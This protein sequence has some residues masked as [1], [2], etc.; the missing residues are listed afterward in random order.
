MKQQTRK[1][2]EIDIN[3][4]SNKNMVKAQKW[5]K[6]KKEYN[7]KEK[8]EK[9][10]NLNISTRGLE[11]ELDLSDF[12]NLEK[13]ECSGNKLTNLN[14]SNCHQ[15]KALYC[16]HNQLTSLNLSKCINLTELYCFDNKLTKLDLTDLTQLE[17]IGC[18][19]NYLTNFDYSSLSSEK[20]NWLNI[21]NNN[22]P[23]QDLSVFSRFINLEGLRIGN[24]DQEKKTKQNIYNRFS[25]S[26]ESLKNLTKLR[27]LD[28]SNTDINRGWECLPANMKKISFSSEERPE[29]KVKEISEQLY[30]ISRGFDIQQLRMW[31]DIGFQ[32]K[33][34]GFAFY[35]T[36]QDY[37]PQAN[38][39]YE[40]L[41]VEYY[42]KSRK[43]Q[44]WLD[45]YYPKEERSE[46]YEIYLNEP[47]LEGELDLGAFTYPYGCGVRVYISP[48]VDETKLI[49][50]NLPKKAEI[51]FLDIQKYINQQYP[52][53]EDREKVTELN[54]SFD[55]VSGKRR[56]EGN[57]DLSEFINLEELTCIGTRLVSLNLNNCSQLEKVNVSNNQL[58]NLDVSNCF[59]LTEIDCRDNSLTDIT[60]PTDP[61]NLKKLDL[62][63]NDFCQDLCF[64]GSYTNLEELYLWNNKFTGSL[65][66][67]SGMKKLR[68]LDISNTDINEVNIDKLPRSLESIKYSTDYNCKLA[69]IVPQLDK[70]KYAFC[71]K[72]QQ[73]NTNN[74]WCQSCADKNWQKNIENLTGKEV[75][76]RFIER[77][78]EERYSD[79]KWIPYEKFASI[80]HLADGGFSKIYKAKWQGKEG[81]WNSKKQ[82]YENY[83]EVVLKFLNN[84]QNI[85]LEFLSEIVNTKLV[86]DRVVRCYGISQDPITKNYAMVMEYIKDG[87]LRQVLQK[88]A[89][90]LGLESKLGC[91]LDIA[92]GL[93]KIHQQ[94]L[95]HCDF[96]S[97]NILNNV[98]LNDAGLRNDNFIESHITDLGLSQPANHQKQEGQIFGVLPYVAPEVLQGQPYTKASDVYS[99]GIIAYELLANAYPYADLKLKETNLTLKICR[100]LRPNIE[101]LKIPQGCKDLLKKCWEADPEKR[102]NARELHEALHDWYE[103]IGRIR[104]NSGTIKKESSSFYRQYQSLEKEYN[105]FSQTTPYQIYS[106]AVLTSKMIDTKQ[107]T[108]QLEKLRVNEQQDSKQV[109]L[110][111]TETIVEIEEQSLQAQQLQ[112]PK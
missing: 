48:Q 108:Q 37:H 90:N 45:K 94:N 10:I 87:N 2:K 47:G 71:Q 9:V 64:L 18:N 104:R 25:G 7:T 29:S 14:I 77:Q 50:K 106:N 13:L 111:L 74:N 68:E 65:E 28:I 107:I 5:L 103:E 44:E 20:L 89:N 12:T 26:L 96:H 15:L 82:K 31:I 30:W 62:S 58:V 11:G 63:E 1:F 19:N 100:G 101:E 59:Y 61:I 69:E 54:A 43:S 8:R 39:N 76:E 72:C 24:D 49:F 38:L 81:E 110:K 52:T 23:E 73:I 86:K 33:D 27:Y 46:V 35:L 78:R 17:E 67:L 80:E 109:D 112:E 36:K 97:G 21:S 16:D 32:P 53:K 66:H 93:N 88:N 6:S 51:V 57:L 56:L 84:S 41:K 105:T 40:K 22:L 85:T 4:K 91:L 98:I 55:S 42:N 70:V 60:L 95:V 75:I 99:F 3:I 92:E 83:K 79:L 102:P 34:Y